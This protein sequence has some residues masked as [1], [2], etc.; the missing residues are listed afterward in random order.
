MN[1]HKIWTVRWIRAAVGILALLCL[2]L[3]YAWSVFVTP[4]EAEFGWGRSQT[5]MTFTIC[6]SFFCIGGLFA[7]YINRFLKPRI[8]L[9][10]AAVSIL[11]GF[12]LSSNISSLPGLFIGYGVFCG[13]GVG[14]GYNVVL[15]CI[16]AWFPEKTGLLSGI[17]LMGFGFG[18][19]V[20]GSLSV[21]LMAAAGWRFAF[22]ILGI[23]LAVVILL[24]SVMLKRPLPEE[25][26]FLKTK[27]RKT[28]SVAKNYSTKEMLHTSS[29]Y[30][31]FIWLVLITAL[32]LAVVSN[33][34][35]LAQTMTGDIGK[36][37]FLAGLVSIFNGIGRLCSGFI[38][39]ALGSK[40]TMRI[41]SLIGLAAGI[42]M[43]LS[44]SAESVL[45][46]TAGFILIGFAFG[47][48]SPTMSAYASRV[49]GPKFYS[50]NFSIMNLCMLAGAFI[51]SF[52]MGV[53]QS[54][55]GYQ[56]I[57]VFLIVFAAASLIFGSIVRLHFQGNRSND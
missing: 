43:F 31:V 5:S 55:S 44:V 11:A 8:I 21:N 53:V 9:L 52:L 49:F 48:G 51:G 22:R 56:T 35:P 10:L 23:I 40:R 4:I 2:G 27:C 12:F 20:L 14:I 24:S 13:F 17:L 18:G 34:S 25:S 32:G 28:V 47:G 54:S 41:Y 37:S 26:E 7:G 42:I 30:F 57:T 45:L 19:S 3:I 6:M 16:L 39:D 38:L 50:N 15:S 46:L 29:F 33:A 36:A 1:N